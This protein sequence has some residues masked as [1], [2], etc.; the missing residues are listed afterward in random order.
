M[1]NKIE[2]IEPKPLG[3]PRF[4]FNEKVLKQ[5]E[6]MASY[7]CSKT[8]IATIIGCSKDTIYRS[9]EAHE[10]YERGVANAKRTIRKTQFDIAVKLNSSMMAIYLGKIYLGQDKDDDNEDYKPLPLGDVI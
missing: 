5:V 8:E 1:D 6:D 4:I 3:R 9:Q 10:A 7:M 2:I